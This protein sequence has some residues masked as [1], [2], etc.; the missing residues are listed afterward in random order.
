MAG[1]AS[2]TARSEMRP[3]IDAGP[4]EPEVQGV[5]G[6]G[7]RRREGR[8]ACSARPVRNDCA[9]IASTATARAIR[10]RRFI[11]LRLMKT[12]R[13]K[14]EGRRQAREN[15]RQQKFSLVPT[16]FP[17]RSGDYSRPLSN[18][19]PTKLSANFS[20]RTKNGAPRRSGKYRPHNSRAGGGRRMA[21]LRTRGQPTADCGNSS[22]GMV[23]APMVCSAGRSCAGRR[24][25][26]SF[27][28]S[29]S[30]SLGRP[31]SGR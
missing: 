1:F 27:Q 25:S 19:R 3:D 18:S 24:S 29:Q 26:R 7:S 5:E 17:F 15:R 14:G 8:C 22:G 11:R 28:F 9:V 10:R 23:D 30:T 20:M 13:A 21:R 6:T 12:H 16:P 2:K 31:A 4:I